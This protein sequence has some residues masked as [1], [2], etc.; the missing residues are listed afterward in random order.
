MRALK[1]NKPMRTMRLVNA[2]ALPAREI[3]SRTRQF[4]APIERVTAIAW[5]EFESEMKRRYALEVLMRKLFAM[6]PSANLV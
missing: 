2:I 4:V 5:W 1:L 6:V 3:V